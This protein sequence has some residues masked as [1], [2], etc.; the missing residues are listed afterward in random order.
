MFQI[1]KAI[2]DIAKLAQGVNR[3]EVALEALKES[4]LTPKQ[5][6]KLEALLKKVSAPSATT[7]PA[8]G[9]IKTIDNHQAVVGQITV[10]QRSGPGS[11]PG[12]GISS[13]Q[14]DFNELRHPTPDK[15]ATLQTNEAAS[16]NNEVH[17]PGKLANLAKYVAGKLANLAKY[18]AYNEDIIPSTLAYAAGSVVGIELFSFLAAAGKVVGLS[19]PVTY[20]V[21]ASSSVIALCLTVAGRRYGAEREGGAAA[22]LKHWLKTFGERIKPIGDM[23]EAYPFWLS[24]G[25]GVAGYMHGVSKSVAIQEVS[26]VVV[27][28]GLIYA[29][30]F[31]VYSAVAGLWSAVT[32]PVAGYSSVI[33]AISMPINALCRAVV[34]L[35][36]V[37][38]QI[39]VNG[40]Q[41]DTLLSEGSFNKSLSAQHEYAAELDCRMATLAEN[42]AYVDSLLAKEDDKSINAD[43]ANALKTYRDRFVRYD[44]GGLKVKGR[45]VVDFHGHWRVGD[46]HP[47][48]GA[49]FV[50]ASAESK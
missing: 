2:Q 38:G 21:A 36:K 31:L 4:E 1:P 32:L 7:S 27:G 10:E 15:E 16:K 49:L 9:E 3:A 39:T 17:Q 40:Q 50:R 48:D 14:L 33:Q 19:S 43:E 47:N 20:A 13:G 6:Q 12:T 44:E 26:A 18:V 34:G 45:R 29:S 30:P 8:V 28:I 23:I 46:G 37:R 35:K 5:V 22:P 42:R 11:H 24:A 41:L 25:V